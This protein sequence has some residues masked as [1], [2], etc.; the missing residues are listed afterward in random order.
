MTSLPSSAAVFAAS[1][2]IGAT[3]PDPSRVELERALGLGPGREPEPRLGS[4]AEGRGGRRPGLAV[5]G[6]AVGPQLG[7]ERDQ[8]C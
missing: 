1:G 4:A 3:L 6:E 5:A 8:L 2:S 7:A